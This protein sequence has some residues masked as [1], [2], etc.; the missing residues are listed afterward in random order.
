MDPPHQFDLQLSAQSSLRFSRL[1]SD[2]DGGAHSLTAHSTHL[3][4][5]LPNAAHG[6]LSESRSLPNH[7]KHV[8]ITAPQEVLRPLYACMKKCGLD[9]Y[10]QGPNRVIGAEAVQILTGNG[11]QVVHGQ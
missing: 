9:V 3:D 1:H 11:R 4:Q 10:R 7:P 2:V 6:Q 5:P 8:L